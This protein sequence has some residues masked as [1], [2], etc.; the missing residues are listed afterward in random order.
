MNREGEKEWDF[1]PLMP[2]VLQAA[3]FLIHF[4]FIGRAK[5]KMLST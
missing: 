1:E 4:Y 5:M 3:G 2:Y